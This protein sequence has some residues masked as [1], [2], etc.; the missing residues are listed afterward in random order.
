MRAVSQ[1][2]HRRRDCNASARRSDANNAL[3]RAALIGIIVVANAACAI[4]FLFTGCVASIIELQETS[5]SQL[6]G[7]AL[8]ALAVQFVINGS[9]VAFGW[10]DSWLP[11]SCRA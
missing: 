4:A 5:L 8:A 3:L 11:G 7:E 10:A 1:P 6:L 9:Q 2:S